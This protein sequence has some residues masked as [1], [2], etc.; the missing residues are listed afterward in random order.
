MF[1]AELKLARFYSRVR[2]AHERECSKS[3][4]LHDVQSPLM[5]CVIIC[6]FCKHVLRLQ[7]DGDGGGGGVQKPIR[8]KQNEQEAGDLEFGLFRLHLRA[9][10]HTFLK[11]QKLKTN[12]KSRICPISNEFRSHSLLQPIRSYSNYIEK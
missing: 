12:C 11:M 6:V 3:T 10:K 8:E 5:I 4:S 2:L 7:C 1:S 9:E